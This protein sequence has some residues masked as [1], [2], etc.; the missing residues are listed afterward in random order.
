MNKVF[1]L[2]VVALGL[3]FLSG[4]ATT[5]LQTQAKT[6]RTI[7][8]SPDVLQSK[9]VF[10]RVTGTSASVLELEEPLK[11]ALQE[12]GVKLVED[13]NLANISLHVNTLFANNLKE[14]SNYQATFGAGVTSGVISRMGGNSGKDS[15][16]IGIAVA[17][18]MGVAQNA[19]ADDTYRAVIDISVRTKPEGKEWSNEDKTRVL[20]EAVKMGLDAKEAKPVM[21]K[22][23]VQKIADI[24]S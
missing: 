18:A 5:T 19:L 6:T 21:E 16:L 22:Q 24:L 3:L 8:L 7:S 12:R 9:S 23:A 10:L 1:S 17:I 2:C 20:V 4:C 15:I 11:K 13:Q 14:A